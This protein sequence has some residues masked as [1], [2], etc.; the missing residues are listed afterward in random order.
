MGLREASN[1]LV[2]STAKEFFGFPPIL[3]EFTNICLKE[4]FEAVPGGKPG[5]SDHAVSVC[6][7]LLSSDEKC[8]EEYLVE[9]E[10]IVRN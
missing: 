3:L 10:G 8:R 6:S 9:K 5:L 7:M 1:L 4:V 2:S